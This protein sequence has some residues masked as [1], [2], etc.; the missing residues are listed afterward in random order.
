MVKHPRKDCHW[1]SPEV[2]DSVFK[3]GKNVYPQTFLEECKYRI[4]RKGIKPFI[5]DNL[6]NSS[7]DRSGEEGFEENSE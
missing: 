5:H 7:Q 1:L 6:E 4:K 3:S 2:I